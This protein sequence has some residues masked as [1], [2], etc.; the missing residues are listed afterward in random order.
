MLEGTLALEERSRATA[1]STQISAAELTGRS[2]LETRGSSPA[3]L[4]E[5]GSILLTR[6]AAPR[7][8]I[9]GERA[10][11]EAGC[12]GI[13][14]LGLARELDFQPLHALEGV[15]LLAPTGFT[16]V[17]SL[18]PLLDGRA[19]WSL[20]ALPPGEPC[21]LQALAFDPSSGRACLSDVVRVEPGP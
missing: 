21:F 19:V 10:T 15:R 14:W 4:V 20:V 18:R 13:A 5:P 2:V 12:S 6:A 11:L 16:E 8:A 3:A 9:E 7:L 17:G 1:S